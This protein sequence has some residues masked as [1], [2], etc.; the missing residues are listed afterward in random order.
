[1]N[2]KVMLLPGD[3]IGPEIMDSAVAVLNMV[4]E[5]FD[6]KIET[7]TALIGG[8]SFNESG[9][10]LTQSTLTKCFEADAILLGAVGGYKWEKLDHLLKPEAALLRLRKELG[11]NINLRPAKVYKDFISASSL[12]DDVVR[13]TDFLVVRELGSGIYYGEPRGYDNSRG[14]NTM[15]YKREEIEKIVRKAFEIA[16][17]RKKILTSVDKANVL[18]VSQLWRNIAEEISGDYPDVELKHLYVDNAAMQIV[19]NPKQ[20]DVIVTGNMFGDILS[21]IAGM[22]TGSLGMLPSAS[23]GNKYALYEPV[24]GSAPDIAGQGVANPVAMIAS[25]AMMFTHSFNLSEAGRLI[26]K[27]IETT[28]LQG[29]RTKDI[30]STGCK[31]V[32]TVEMAG[33]ICNN[34]NE[35]CETELT[36]IKK[37]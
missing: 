35:I 28:L 31:L 19:H 14:Y 8:V 29:Y 4:A 2:Y 9:T 32:N 30:F 3:G 5:K 27:A 6:M 13:G 23:I 15:V 21:D 17:E 33:L 7:E 11:L 26:E 16:R 12:K 34:I 22:I 37:N 36:E 20:F 24:H 10:P 18:E 25:V 1:M